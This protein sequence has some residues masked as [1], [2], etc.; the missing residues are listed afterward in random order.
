MKILH[1]LD[2]NILEIERQDRHTSYQVKALEKVKVK[3]CEGK[4]AEAYGESESGSIYGK[5]ERGI[6]ERK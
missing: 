2:Q 3:A 6:I 5:G 4:H 1:N